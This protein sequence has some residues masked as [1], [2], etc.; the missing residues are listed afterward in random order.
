[1]QFDRCRRRLEWYI[2]GCLPLLLS[3][4]TGETPPSRER[5]RLCDGAG[6]L[7]AFRFRLLQEHFIV[8]AVFGW[9]FVEKLGNLKYFMVGCG[10]LGCEFLKNFA[11]SSAWVLV[12]ASKRH[13]HRG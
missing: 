11:Q 9:D 1:M 6:F 7:A 12:Y 5:E 2:E 8:A 10:A 3:L 4:S 13:S